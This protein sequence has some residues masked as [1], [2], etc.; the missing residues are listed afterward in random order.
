MYIPGAGT[1]DLDGDGV[2]DVNIATE[3]DPGN[4]SAGVPTFKIG[5]NL[6][7]ANGAA[8]SG[9]LTMHSIAGV[10]AFKRAW[11][12]DRDYL[13]PIPTNDR[14]LTNGALAQNP[15]WNDGLGL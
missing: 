12:E 5:E 9:Y 15:G 6:T 1:L 8:T 14:I 2:P 4:P 3:D 11:N 7:L 10:N 13:Y